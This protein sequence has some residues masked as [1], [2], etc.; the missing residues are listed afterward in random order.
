MEQNVGKKDK[1]LR[2]AI[3]IV[4]LV[5]TFTS[6]WWFIIPAGIA[7]LTAFLGVCGIYSLF[8]MNTCK[9]K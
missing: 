7:F 1:I 5:L 9:Y 8:G 3:A 4:C 6:S 2:Y